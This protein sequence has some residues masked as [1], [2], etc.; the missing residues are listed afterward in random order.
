MDSI[1]TFNILA[2]GRTCSWAKHIAI[3]STYSFVTAP[4]Y[5]WSIAVLRHRNL[6]QYQHVKNII[7][8]KVASMH[9]IRIHSIAA[10]VAAVVLYYTH[11][12]TAAKPAAALTGSSL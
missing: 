7:F 9:S 12:T 6:Q 1:A 5:T 4:L 2:H 10:E 3:F 11:S 8:H